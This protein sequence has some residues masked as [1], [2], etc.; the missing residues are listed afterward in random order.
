LQGRPP[1]RRPRRLTHPIEEMA[2]RRRQLVNA[3]NG[4][5]V[6]LDQVGVN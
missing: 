6:E 5:P 4:N 1:R 2:Q 3:Y